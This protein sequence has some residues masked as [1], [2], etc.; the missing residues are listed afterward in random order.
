MSGSAVAL[1]DGA[2]AAFETP[3]FLRWFPSAFARCEIPPDRVHLVN[4][5]SGKGSMINPSPWRERNL[6][7]ENE[8][9]S[10][11]RT[12]YDITP[13]VIDYTVKVLVIE[14]A[15]YSGI[16]PDVT[17]IDQPANRSSER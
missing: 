14:M 4:L 1:F 5:F 15:P 16:E 6:G 12:S 8:V 9:Q 11:A 7:T 3:R 10:P 17:D 2:A 13:V